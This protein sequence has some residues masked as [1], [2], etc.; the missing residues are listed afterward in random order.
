VRVSEWNQVAQVE[1]EL[2]QYRDRTVGLLRK[3][4]RMSIEL[5]HLPALFGREFFRTNISAYQTHTFEDTVIFVHDMERVLARLKPEAQQILARI[6]FQEFTYDEAAS[7]LGISRRHLVRK[8]ADALDSC[9]RVLLDHGILERTRESL[10]AM[11]ARLLSQKEEALA[12][13]PPVP[14]GVYKRPLF[15]NYC[16]VGK[17]GRIKLCS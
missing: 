14:V 17:D 11:D 7:L 4:F 1:G 13:M 8:I 5:G 10:S 15:P 3:F 12:K 6:F 9:S 2:R 16:Q